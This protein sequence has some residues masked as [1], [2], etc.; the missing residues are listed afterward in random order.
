MTDKIFCGSAK[1]IDGKFG[2]F[3]KLSFSARDLDA[4]CKHADP[5]SGWVN[6]VVSK[7]REPSEKGVTHY[8]TVDTWKH[9]EPPDADSCPSSD[10][11]S[12]KPEGVD[13]AEGDLPF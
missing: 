8:L 5:E 2:K 3:L 4:L 12:M 1:T 6:A 7:R 13:E 11:D 9:P 10:L